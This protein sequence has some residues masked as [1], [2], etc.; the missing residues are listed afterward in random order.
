MKLLTVYTQS[1][2]QMLEEWF[3]PTLQ[4]DYE[5]SSFFCDVEGG[6]Q[7]LQ[8]D[9]SRAVLFKS[10]KI[11]ET[12]KENMG[13]VFVYADVDIEFFGPT[14]PE[15]LNAIEQKDIVCQLDNPYG[16]L[17][18]GFFAIRANLLTLRLWED[19]YKAA[20]IENRDQM[21]FNRII[22]DMKNIRFGYMSSQFFGT[23]T[24]HA[25]D[26]EEG[27][28]FYIPRSP[29]MYHANYTIGVDNKITLLKQV[30]E[31]V[32][33]G[34]GAIDANNVIF[35]LNRGFKGKRSVADFYKR[36]H[37]PKKESVQ[38]RGRPTR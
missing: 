32:N 16:D 28:K 5:L 20:K 1:H 4:D 22:R 31:V 15:I 23:G 29:L 18:T 19:V 6:G 10:R 12:I 30:R 11:I 8:E 2:R 37:V 24:Y 26:W 7:Y 34:N 17:C 21:A 14:K 25:E 9:W 38:M 13:R 33:K 36:G 35:Y 27:S 3:L